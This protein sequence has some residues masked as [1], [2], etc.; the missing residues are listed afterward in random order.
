MRDRRNGRA[1]VK[2]NEDAA[3]VRASVNSVKKPLYPLTEIT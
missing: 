2:R 3:G 1:E